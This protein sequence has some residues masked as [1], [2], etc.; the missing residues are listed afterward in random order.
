MHISDGI[1]EP[2]WSLFWIA[3]TAIFIALGLRIINKHIKN[4]PH[5]FLEF[6]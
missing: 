1:L 3:I 4:D 6:P 5:I 2:Q